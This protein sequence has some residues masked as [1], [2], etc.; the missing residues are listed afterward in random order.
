MTDDATLSEFGSTAEDAADS[1]AEDESE[2][3]QRATDTGLSTYAW[4]TYRCSRCN[5]DT[6]R[7]WRSNGDLVCPACKSW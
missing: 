5:G 3:A 1:T 2:P 7:V 6:E 4:G